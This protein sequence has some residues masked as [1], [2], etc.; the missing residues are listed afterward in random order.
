MD[1]VEKLVP[2]VNVEKC[3][4]KE[5]LVY[6]KDGWFWFEILS[7]STLLI[8]EMVGGS[9]GAIQTIPD[10]GYWAI[11]LMLLINVFIIANFWLL[12]TF[13]KVKGMGTLRNKEDAITTLNF[14]Y[15]DLTF[16]ASK[17]NMLRNIKPSTFSKWGSAL[18]DIF[19]NDYVY[20]HRATITDR[21]SISPLSGI[22]NY[23]K[24]KKIAEHFQQIQQSVAKA[25]SV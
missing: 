21:I 16:S 2:D 3:L 18:T 19:N 23:L 11:V 12:N 25:E 20:F 5:R 4:K 7:I 14:F 10:N 17:T 15:E 6:V 24:C 8:I 1:E 9:Y 22:Y 13:V